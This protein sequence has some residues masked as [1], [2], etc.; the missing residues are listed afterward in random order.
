MGKPTSPSRASWALDH[1][2]PRI[3]GTT[4]NRIRTDHCASLMLRGAAS[5]ALRVELR[6]LEGPLFMGATVSRASLPARSR[7]RRL[8]RLQDQPLTKYSTERSKSIISHGIGNLLPTL[9]WGHL[10]ETGGY[11]PTSA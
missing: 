2:I 8:G 3:T 7:R 5:V 9:G 6:D 11:Q 10:V 1:W 4:S